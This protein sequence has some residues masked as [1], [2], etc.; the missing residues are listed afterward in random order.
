MSSNL[1]LIR[2]P[3]LAVL[4]CVALTAGAP[5][6][7]AATTLPIVR[8]KATCVPPRYPGSGYFTDKIHVTNV[9]CAYAKKFIVAFYK[10]RTRSGRSPSGRC[11][12]RVQGFLCTEYRKSIPTE[13]DARVTCRR[14]TQRIV[15]SYQQNLD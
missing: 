10:C 13:I 3:T 5:A 12:T 4:A 9:S 1:R 6:G 7:G 11:R 14:V 15:H 8:G 2:I